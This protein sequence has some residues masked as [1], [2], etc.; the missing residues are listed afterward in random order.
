MR[1][2]TRI[3]TTASAVVLF[4]TST[5]T[6]AFGA[7][8]RDENT[9]PA[10]PLA[11]WQTDGIVWSVTYAHGVVYVR[12]T[13]DNVRPPG[14]APGEKD[15]A[16]KNFAAFDAVTGKLLPCAHSFTQ[17]E[18]T[19][20]T[21]KATRDGRVLYADGSFGKVEHT[22]V[23]SAVALNTADCSLR[24]DFRPAVA[25]PVRAIEPTDTAVYLGGGDFTVVD[26]KTRKRIASFRRNGALLPFRA[27]IDEP[28]RVILVVPDRAR[29]TVGGDFHHVSGKPDQSL[30]RLNSTTGSTVT[31]FP[32]W[33]PERSSVTSPARTGNRFHLGAQGKGTGNFDSRIAGRLPDGKMIW[34]D[35]CLGATRAVVVYKG[36][37]YSASHAYY[38]GQTPGGWFPD[39]DDGIGERIGP[40]ALVMAGKVPRA[41]PQ[42]APP[43]MGETSRAGKATLT[44]RAAW[45]RDNVE[46]TY[47]LYRD[48]VL[49][50]TPKQRSAE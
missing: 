12:G 48:G 43:L 19:V 5:L 3:V 25:G 42:T 47:L 8:T 41:A 15:V 35:T 32:D 49:V 33:L 10:V 34:K 45:D 16:R 23:A 20:R 7:Q 17:G 27:D 14:A 37:L 39:T 22:R 31:S 26:G 38:C 21:L 30:A 24:G 2:T 28:V 11:T 40:R 46:L 29:V 1:S 44:W 36:V 18:G 50:V 4:A 13:F 6:T 9:L